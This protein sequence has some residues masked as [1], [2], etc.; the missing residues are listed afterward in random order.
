MDDIQGSKHANTKTPELKVLSSRFKSKDDRNKRK[1]KKELAK[2]ELE[3][4]RSELEEVNNWKEIF[5]IFLSLQMMQK[6]LKKSKKEN[7]EKIK[8]YIVTENGLGKFF[9]LDSSLD[10]HIIPHVMWHAVQTYSLKDIT[11]PTVACNHE[12]Y[13]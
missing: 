4:K 2:E 12:N 10:P 13:F 6:T 5:R 1:S 8:A 3:K 9:L 11:W 7:S